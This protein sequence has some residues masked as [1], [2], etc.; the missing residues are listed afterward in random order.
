MQVKQ[1]SEEDKTRFKKLYPQGSEP[2]DW[3]VIDPEVAKDAEDDFGVVEFFETEEEA[4]KSL[5]EW[6]Q[7]DLVEDA[8]REAVHKIAEQV[9]IEVEK[10]TEIAKGFF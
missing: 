10:V 8:L 2:K 4:K 3:A 1:F 5:E 6:R 9:G 7:L